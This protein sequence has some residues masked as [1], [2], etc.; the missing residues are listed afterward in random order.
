M[1][2]FVCLQNFQQALLF[3]KR[4]AANAFSKRSRLIYAVCKDCDLIWLYI[5]AKQ[6]T[7]GRNFRHLYFHAHFPARIFGSSVPYFSLMRFPPIPVRRHL[8]YSVR[9][10][11]CDVNF[12]QGSLHAAS[13]AS[14]VT[15]SSVCTISSMEFRKLFWFFLHISACQR[16]QNRF[17]LPLLSISPHIPFYYYGRLFSLPITITSS[18]G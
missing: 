15:P 4:A 17:L 7:S 12:A 14:S 11:S 9:I 3:M 16:I 18:D 6:T 10:F 5:L 13:P 1:K 8:L 2:Q